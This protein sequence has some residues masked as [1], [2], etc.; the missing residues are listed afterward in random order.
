MKKSV[1]R[2]ERKLQ[3]KI[4]A[5]IRSRNGLACKV[6]PFNIIGIPDLICALP[7]TSLFFLEVKTDTGE[8]SKIQTATIAWLKTLGVD[9]YV[10]YGIMDWVELRTRLLSKV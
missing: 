10:V 4:I 3:P 2:P 8:L 1:S 9:A 7:G 6:L 5:D